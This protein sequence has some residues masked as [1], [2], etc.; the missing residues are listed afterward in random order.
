MTGW[1]R[2][3]PASL[4][5]AAFHAAVCVLVL[6]SVRAEARQVQDSCDQLPQVDVPEQDWPTLAQAYSANVPIPKADRDPTPPPGEPEATTWCDAVSLYY[7]NSPAHFEKARYCVLANFGLLRGTVDPAKIKMAQKAASGGATDP[8]MIDEMSG[9]VLAMV[10][11][12]GEGV[13]RNLPLARQFLCQYSGGIQG[14]DPAQHLVEFDRMVKLGER[15]DVCADG[16]GGFG[17][18]ANY[19][20]LGLEQDQR[21]K[22]IQRLETEVTTSSTPGIKD[23]FLALVS[24]WEKFHKAYGAMDSAMCDGGTGCGPYTRDDD[25]KTTSSWLAALESIQ[26]GV[27]PASGA[28]PSK[29]AQ[30]DRDLNR[31]YRETLDKSKGCASQDCFAM[32]VR[33]ADRAWLEYREAWVRFGALRWPAIAADQ[34][35][36]WQT[37]IW[38]SLL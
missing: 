2:T 22:E 14:E 6:G 18:E 23:S 38:S 31:Q 28:D 10:F 24:A 3:A 13:A 32:Q 9:L 27:A 17:R 8:E 5:R 16:G 37:A 7:S 34:W 26:R 35:R 36:A 30:F 19:V 15:L 12:N 21:A 11:G 4:K 1:K 25:L 20:C 29:F 33:V